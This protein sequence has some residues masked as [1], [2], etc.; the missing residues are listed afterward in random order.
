MDTLP[1]CHEDRLDVMKENS[2][3]FGNSVL[4]ILRKNHHTLFYLGKETHLM[5]KERTSEIFLQLSRVLDTYVANRE[6]TK[7]ETLP[8]CDE[9]F[10]SLPQPGSPSFC[11]VSV[12]RRTSGVRRE[13]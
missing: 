7:C 5:K 9:L 8:R 13:Q 11:A 12:Y 10:F 4:F 1:Q 6:L 3:R 2:E